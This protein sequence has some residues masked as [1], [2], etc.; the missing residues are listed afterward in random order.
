MN[1]G[2]PPQVYLYKT[3][4]NVG[5]RRVI[6]DMLSCLCIKGCYELGTLCQEEELLPRG[7]QLPPY[8]SW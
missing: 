8:I 4:V 2:K 6:S 3:S 1:P 5:P 7:V